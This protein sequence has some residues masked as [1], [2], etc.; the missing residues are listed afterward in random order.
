MS[1]FDPLPFQQ[2]TSSF[3]WPNFSSHLLERGRHTETSLQS[4]TASRKTGIVRN[5]LFDLE[6]TLYHLWLKKC[7]QYFC[8][9][10]TGHK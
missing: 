9:N 7:R 2:E 3:I 1:N 8:N 4:S 10:G 5:A 6:Y